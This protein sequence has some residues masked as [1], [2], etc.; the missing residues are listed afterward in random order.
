MD[1]DQGPQQKPS[2]SNTAT[3]SF[4]D[5][6]CAVFSGY[7]IVVEAEGQGVFWIGRLYAPLLRHYL[8][9]YKLAAH[10]SARK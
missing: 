9:V 8:T 2:L 5:V 4:S 6:C 1:D 10:E 3:L 7:P